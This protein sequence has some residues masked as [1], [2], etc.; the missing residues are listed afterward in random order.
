MHMRSTRDVYGDRVRLGAPVDPVKCEHDCV[1]I[2]HLSRGTCLVQ[3][4]VHILFNCS[5]IG[6]L[7]FVH[8][9]DCS[10]AVMC[11]T[12]LHDS[13][14]DVMPAGPHTPNAG[15]ACKSVDFMHAVASQGDCNINVTAIL[16]PADNSNAG[17]SS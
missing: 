14:T 13:C 9:L 12:S 7:L 16:L 3:K 17:T 11:C 6:L 15:S 4:Y 8:K 10:T 5:L 1:N 2:I